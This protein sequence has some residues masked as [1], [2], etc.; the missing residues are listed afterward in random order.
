MN[1]KTKLILGFGLVIILLVSISFIYNR[2]IE[3]SNHSQEEIYNVHIKIG[4]EVKILNQYLLELRK[5]EMQFLLSKDENLMQSH[6]ELYDKMQAEN[7]TLIELAEANGYSEILS[8]LN[9]I[10]EV[11]TKYETAFVKLFEAC[12]SAGFNHKEGLQ[13]KFRSA[14]HELGGIMKAH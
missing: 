9:E 6:K 12:K 4:D 5:I 10:K 1:L 11:T 14:A 13:G 2:T 7:T 8:Q 3:Q